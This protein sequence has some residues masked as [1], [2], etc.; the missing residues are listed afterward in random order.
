MHVYAYARMVCM[1][2]G[3]ACVFVCAH[4]LHGLHARMVCIHAWYAWHAWYA[5]VSNREQPDPAVADRL[6]GEDDDEPRASMAYMRMHAQ[7]QIHAYSLPSK[8]GTHAHAY[9]DT[10]TCIQSPGRG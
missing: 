3:H 6:V 5:C 4:G 1:V 8:Y 9:T 2:C 7:I 10:D